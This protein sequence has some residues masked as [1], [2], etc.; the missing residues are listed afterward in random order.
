MNRQIRWLR[1]ELPGWVARGVVSP[2]QA[3]AIRALYP[4]PKTSLPWSMLVFS[5]VGAVVIDR[6][7]FG[8]RVDRPV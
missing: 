5:G 8:H 1:Q 7:A 4:E 6:G 2:A 3:G